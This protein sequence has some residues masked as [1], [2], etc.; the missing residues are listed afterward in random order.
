VIEN[1]TAND[2]TVSNVS[3]KHP[4]YSAPL[5]G[6]IVLVMMICEK[7]IAHTYTSMFIYVIPAPWKYIVPAIIGVVGMYLIIRGMGK[8]EVKGSMLGYLGAVLVWMSWFEPGLPALARFNVI[9]MVKNAEN[10]MAGLMGE[11]VILQMSFLFCLMSLFFIMLNKDVRCRMLLWIRRGLGL[12]VGT[13]TLKYNPVVARVAA[14][15]Y[16]FV[17]WFMYGVMLLIVDPRMFGLYHPV[18]YA[19]NAA[20]VGWGL[21]LIYLL[22]KQ[23]EVGMA[24]RYGIGVV[25]VAWFIPEC[26]AFY[27]VFYEFY[28]YPDKHPVP[29]VLSLIAFFGSIW[30]LWRVPVNPTTQ[31]SL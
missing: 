2:S 25:G 21:Y 13:P 19:A 15:E 4:G 18:T 20:L 1:Q 10:P 16:F 28:L 31:R 23:R 14:F 3:A 12:K 9:P 24:I 17:T 27:E 29:F 11:H 30:W 5:L 22:T 26:F 8:D 7:M 6:V